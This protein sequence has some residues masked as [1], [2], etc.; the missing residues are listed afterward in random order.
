M[1]EFLKI[2]YRPPEIFRALKARPAWFALFILLAVISVALLVLQYPALIRSTL[3]HLPK[4]ATEPDRARLESWMSADLIRRGAFLPIRL[5]AGWSAFALLL[6]AGARA[7]GV[8]HGIRY[9]H[10]LSLELHAE[11]AMVIGSA[12]AVAG[13]PGA[14][15]LYSPV[16]GGAS[17]LT[18]LNLCTLW[19][20]S[21][22]IWGVSVL[23]DTSPRKAFLIVVV[24]WGIGQAFNF[25]V[26]S[27]LQH[28]FRLV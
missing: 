14:G 13:V 9:A 23:C 3:E 22:L 5:L 27:L 19:Y 8:A 15:V 7:F 2:L 24:S 28:T 16:M 1:F 21:L 18:T 25:G 20:V 17:L 4:G 11:T 12:L 26:L 10:L 6:Y